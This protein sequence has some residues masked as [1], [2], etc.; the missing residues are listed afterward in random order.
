MTSHSL[1]R[2]TPAAKHV[3]AAGIT[4]F[5]DDVAAAGLELHSFMLWRAGAVVAEG[6]WRPYAAERPHM[7]HSATKSWTAAAVGL[8]I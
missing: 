6:F 5:L 3:D 1:P 2:A 7:Q 4:A 8:A